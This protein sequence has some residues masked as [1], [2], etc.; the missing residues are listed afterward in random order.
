MRRLFLLV[1]PA[2]SKWLPA[3]LTDL[4]KI[5]LENDV[6]QLMRKVAVLAA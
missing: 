6:R 3:Q 2:R 5:V 4:G 1:W